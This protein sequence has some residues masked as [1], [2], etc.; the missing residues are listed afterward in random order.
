MTE[1]SEDPAQRALKVFLRCNEA[2]DEVIGRREIVE[3]AGMEE[4]VVVA[5]EMDGEV[6][7]GGVGGRVGGVTKGCIPAGLGVEEFD[8]GMVAELGFEMAT[9]FVDTREELRAQRATLGEQG[10]KRGLGRGAEGE[11][12]IGDDFEAIEGGADLRGRAGDG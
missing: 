3:V 10:W 6:F 5:E 9:I 1:F 8:G 12:G 11:I 2:E 7:V 4:D